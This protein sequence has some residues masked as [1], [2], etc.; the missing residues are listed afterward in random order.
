MSRAARIKQAVTLLD[1]LATEAL[2]A[3][4]VAT[5]FEFESRSN[6]AYTV[7]LAIS[8]VNKSWD[9]LIP[10]VCS[11]PRSKYN[12]YLSWTVA[13]LLECQNVSRSIDVEK[14]A[15][16][17][18]QRQGTRSIFEERLLRITDQIDRPTSG[19]M[20]CYREILAAPDKYSLRVVELMGKIKKNAEAIKRFISCLRWP[21][22]R[23]LVFELR[24]L[25]LTLA[26]ICLFL[27]IYFV[28]IY[29]SAGSLDPETIRE[30]VAIDADRLKDTW[31]ET[32]ASPFDRLS[33]TAN[34]LYQLTSIVPLLLLASTIPLYVIR[35]FVI[36]SG[37]MRTKLEDVQ[38]H[39][40]N[41]A[42]VVGIS[43]SLVNFEEISVKIT[44]TDV[45]GQNNIV[46]VNVA[47]YMR[48]VSNTVGDNLKNSA[49]PDEVKELVRQL[50]EQINAIADRV[51]PALAQKMGKNL[52]KISEEMAEPTPDRKWYQLSLE[53]LKE[54]A[55]AVGAIAGPIIAT[56]GKLK[57]LLGL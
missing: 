26:A 39:L 45:S 3:A 57:P 48:N 35:R 32:G 9:Q 41:A 53:G 38:N 28:A 52:K 56:V 55:E 46:N 51:E 44:K 21:L 14:V 13:R 16:L 7:D 33:E 2:M 17:L 1:N 30:R 12:L 15:E 10:E 4:V 50:T 25:H 27:G 5:Y 11:N 47:E 40:I 36:Q 19:V 54:A 49:S 29:T 42:K 20:A 31:R 23:W 37:R 18:K 34:L 22:V 8:H 43:R 6:T 24:P